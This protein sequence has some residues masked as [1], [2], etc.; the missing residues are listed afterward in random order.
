ML[1]IRDVLR[2]LRHKYLNFSNVN[3]SVCSPFL[4]VC[5]TYIVLLQLISY[6]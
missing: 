3:P 1:S 5:Y 2:Y 6:Y 4:L